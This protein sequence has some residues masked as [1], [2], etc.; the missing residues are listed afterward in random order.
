MLSGVTRIEVSRLTSPIGAITLFARDGVAVAVDFDAGRSDPRALL[1]K[2]FPDAAF[3]EGALA[4]LVAP[5][6]RY[7]DGDLKALEAIPV[8]PGGTVF[9]ARVWKALR[10]IPVGR[11]L[12]YGELARKLGNPN[13]MRAVGLAN[14]QNPIGVVIPCHRVIGADGSLTGYGG[15]ID[16]KRWLLAHEGVLPPEQRPLFA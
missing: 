6:E 13:A 8:D 15:G 2:R 1:L 5:L 4:G 16:R 10:Q 3:A 7:F 14:G 11:T 9:Q 12:S